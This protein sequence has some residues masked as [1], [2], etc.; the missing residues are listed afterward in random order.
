[1]PS[2]N[3]TLTGSKHRINQ[4]FFLLQHITHIT[5]Q[6]KKKMARRAHCLVLPYPAQGH[7]NPMLHFSKLLEPQGVRVTLVTTRSYYKNM[8]RVPSNIA[9]ETISDGFDEGGIVEAGNAKV[10]L[11]T[12]WRVGPETLAELLEKLGESK[13]HVNCLIYDSFLPWAL[14]VAKRFG[15]AGASYL[16]QNMAVHCIYYHVYL[17]KLQ[18]PLTEHDEI[19]LPALPKLL[20]QDIPSFLLEED[21]TLIDLVVGQFSNFDKA[22]WILCNTF[23]ELDKEAIDWAT[24]IWPKLKTIGPSIPTFFLDNQCEDGQDYQ[25]TKF[26]SEECIEWLDDKPKGSVVYVSFGSFVTY[27]EE[28]MEEFAS[29]LRECSNYYLWVVRASE[30]NKLPKDFEKKTE[31]GLVVTWCSQLKVLSHEAVGCFVTHCGWNSTLET[32]CLGVPIIGIP[33]WSDQT[34]N[35]KLASDVWKI[36]IRAPISEKKI[37]RRE[38]LK[39]CIQEIMERGKEMK[40]NAIQWRNL[41][42]KAISRANR[43][44]SMKVFVIIHSNAKTHREEACEECATIIEM[45]VMTIKVKVTRVKKEINIR[46]NVTKDQT[47]SYLHSPTHHTKMEKQIKAHCLVLPYPAQG[48]INPMIQFSKLLEHQGVKITLITTRSYS[49]NLLKVPPSIALETIS[50]GYD[51]GGL[52]EAGSYKAYL[53]RFNQVGAETLT[54]LLEKLEHVDCLIYDAFFPWALDVAKRLGIVAASYLTQ[55]M[56]VNN[57]YYHVHLGKLRAP[58]TDHETSL[59]MLPTLQHEDMP[60]FF[61]TYAED[62]TL[63]DFVVGQFSNIHK[64]DWILCN[65]FYDLDKEIINLFMEIWPKFRSIGP[66]IP[67]MLLDKRFEGDQDYEVTQF[68]SDKCMEWLDCKPKGSVVYVSFGSLATFDEKQMEEVAF[69]LRENSSYFLWVVRA[70]EENKLPKNFEK[71]SEKGLIVTWCSQPKVLA[72]KAIGCFVTHCGWN[73]TLETLCLGVPTIA[74]PCWS[75]QS[76]NAKLMKDVWKIGIKAP[77]DDNKIVQQKVLKHCIEEVMES[78]RGKKMKNNALQWKTLAGKAISD[79][80]RKEAGSVNTYLDRFGQVGPETLAELVEKLDHTFSS[81]NPMMSLLTSRFV[82]IYFPK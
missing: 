50:D 43:E 48:H 5:R 63:F 59:P 39:D 74:I 3:C 78:E 11:D 54:E 37:V 19:S 68:K 49:K 20:P 17:G 13:N 64:A 32:L 33:W 27:D 12:F 41:A 44:A 56:A 23:Y 28:Q 77:F 14:D 36:G 35:T 55:N 9:V 22:D 67:S 79:G 57:I 61:F 66:N 62:P 42:V 75:D 4:P 18:V 51:Q 40:I 72:H 15:I 71:I 46:K 34:T 6:K 38:A 30:E 60:S 65:T 29:C 1:M 10:Y 81:G 7:I 16:T 21:R 58:L 70:S 24:K 53:E 25:V 26:K 8:Q 80:G 47:L 69:C 73:S 82:F 45:E 31:K 2:T 76:T 52:T